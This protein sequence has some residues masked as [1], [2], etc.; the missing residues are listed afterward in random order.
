MKKKSLIIGGSIGTIA[1]LF[2]FMTA[3]AVPSVSASNNC[4]D[5]DCLKKKLR[6]ICELKTDESEYIDYY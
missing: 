6:L 1:G 2:L 5:T 4:V 3:V